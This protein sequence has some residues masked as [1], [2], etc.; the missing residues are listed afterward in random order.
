M[1]CTG[2]D[3]APLQTRCRWNL[4]RRGRSQLILVFAVA[5]AS[6]AGAYLLFVGVRGAG[7]WGTTNNGEFVD[8]PM[9]A[10]QLQVVGAD[11]GPFQTGGRWW[12]WITAP[13]GCAARCE[14]ALVATAQLRVLLHK[15]ADRVKRGLLLEMPGRLPQGALEVPVLAGELVLL[16]AGVYIVDPLG[17][18]VLWYSFDDV[19]KRL[20][21]DLKRLLKVSQI[22]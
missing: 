1:C 6:L 12:L 11:G 17:N 21:D 10:E 14:T 13:D 3:P 8:P 22:G 19:G 18:L 4:Q 2:T 5:A 20:L 15:D 16:R 7:P 9:S